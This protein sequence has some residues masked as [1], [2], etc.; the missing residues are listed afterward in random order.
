MKYSKVMEIL[1]TCSV[2][3]ACSDI[4]TTPSKDKNVSASEGELFPRSMQENAKYYLIS[5]ESDGDYLKTLHSRVSTMSH[6]YSVTRIDC[7]G[8]R[9]QDL[10]YGED[11]KSNIKM[12]DDVAWGELVSGSSKSDLVSFVCRK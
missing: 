5:V 11:A 2:I 8:Q 4:E 1:V 10:G 6:G 7:T 9:Y 12:Y 3:V